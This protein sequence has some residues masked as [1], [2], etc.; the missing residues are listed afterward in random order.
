[1]SDV[2]VNLGDI[3]LL[4]TPPNGP[5]FCIPIARTSQRKYLFVSLSTRRRKSDTSCVL[6]PGEGVPD[7]IV[8]ESIIQYQ[9]ARELDFQGLGRLSIGKSPIVKASCSP[10]LLMRIQQGG[11]V[12]KQLR[13]GLKK[14][15]RDFLNQ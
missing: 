10:E 1:M 8:N 9:F 15:L 2:F 13:N 7:L 6:I 14:L 3:Y 12:S 11:L 4:D 5:H